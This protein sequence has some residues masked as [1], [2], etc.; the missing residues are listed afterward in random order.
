DIA[1]APTAL[2]NAHRMFW[3]QHHH[4]IAH[5]VEIIVPGAFHGSSNAIEDLKGVALRMVVDVMRRL[6]GIRRDGTVFRSEPT[7]NVEGLP[8]RLFFIFRPEIGVFARMAEGGFICFSRNTST[9]VHQ[10][11]PQGPPDGSIGSETA[12]QAPGFTIDIESAGNR[13]IDHEGRRAHVG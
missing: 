8:G 6:T 12:A 7:L 10:D 3:T 4:G 5:D 11:E 9:E 1:L 13:A 2:C